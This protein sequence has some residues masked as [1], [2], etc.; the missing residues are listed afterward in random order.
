MEFLLAAISLGFLGS[1]HCIGMCGPIALALPIGGARGIQ[2]VLLI[3]T[4][5]AGRMLTYA[6]LGLISGALGKGFMLA[7]FQQKLSVVLGIL[8]LAAVIFPRIYRG[9]FNPA[10]PVDAFF[11]VIKTR[12]GKLF[13]KKGHASLFTIGFLNGLL[14]CGLVYMALALA[15]ALGDPLQSA[16]FM[17][18]FG[19]GTAPVMIGLPLFGNFISLPVRNKIRK[20]VPVFMSVMAVLLI[21]RGLNLGIPYISPKIEPAG[22]ASCHQ[23]APVAKCCH[24]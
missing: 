22:T 16:L 11:N 20:A 13:S 19:F 6:V 15:L 7:G 18:V 4:Y 3:L 2:R 17:A 12:L 14:P 21:L 8:I 1:F 24:K 10:R 9:N 5:N 23:P